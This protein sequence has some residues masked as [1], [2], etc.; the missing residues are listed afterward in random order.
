MEATYRVV[1]T[2]TTSNTNSTCYHAAAA[3]AWELAIKGNG[4]PGPPKPSLIPHALDPADA[5]PSAKRD[6]PGLLP[7]LLRT[8]KY[9]RLLELAETPVTPDEPLNHESGHNPEAQAPVKGVDG[10]HVPSI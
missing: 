4:C 1:S 6:I 9:R 7:G 2:A 10:S 8:S 3:R 5:T